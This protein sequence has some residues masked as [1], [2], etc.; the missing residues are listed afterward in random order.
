MASR[1]VMLPRVMRAAYHSRGTVRAL[2]RGM[3]IAIVPLLAAIAGLL[4]YVLASNAKVVEVGRI[5]LWTGVLL[6]LYVSTAHTVR[7]G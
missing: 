7:I 1:A 3:L 2:L 5:L 6:T 4:I